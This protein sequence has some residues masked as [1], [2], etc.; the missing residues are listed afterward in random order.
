M[1]RKISDNEPERALERVLASQRRL[2][3][4]K[5]PGIIALVPAYTT[6]ALFYDPPAVMDAGATMDNVLGWLDQRISEAL[7][8]REETNAQPVQSSVI[9]IPVCYD[10]E[11]AFD[12][13]DVAR[14]ATLSPDEVI[15]VSFWGRIPR[16][17]YRIHWRIP[18]SWRFTARARHAASRKPAQGNSSRVGRHR[19]KTNWD[20]SD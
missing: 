7:S 3:A 8:K 11:F 19:R 10:K 1:S 2:T 5:I 20:L 17:L 18:I 15:A 16:S 14:C 12:L 9:E 6:I 13:D 4:A